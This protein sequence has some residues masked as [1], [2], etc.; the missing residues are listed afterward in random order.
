[1]QQGLGSQIEHSMEGLSKPGV[2]DVTGGS[3]EGRKTTCFTRSISQIK[4][5]ME[6][7]GASS[8]PDTQHC[9]LITELINATKGCLPVTS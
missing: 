2:M 3:A 6:T 8:V 9:T 7:N 1:M 4:E 5:Q